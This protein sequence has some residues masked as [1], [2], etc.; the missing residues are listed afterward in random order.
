MIKFINYLFAF[1][2]GF[3]SGATAFCVIQFHYCSFM[4]DALKHMH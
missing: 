3:F 1:M 4:K 2:F